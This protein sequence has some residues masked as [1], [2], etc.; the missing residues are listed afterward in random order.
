MHS[1]KP[2]KLDTDSSF[3]ELQTVVKWTN[4]EVKITV[5]GETKRI[6][7]NFSGQTTNLGL[8]AI[9]GEKFEE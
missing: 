7:D 2:V 5:K 4:L 6:L 9:L 8:S 1:D 3:G